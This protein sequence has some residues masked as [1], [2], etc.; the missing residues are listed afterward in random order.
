MNKI[1]SNP[2]ENVFRGP[3]SVLIMLG[4]DLIRM[5]IPRGNALVKTYSILPWLIVL[6]HFHPGGEPATR[7]CC[8]HPPY[9][10]L[11]L[12]VSTMCSHP[13]QITSCRVHVLS[14]LCPGMCSRNL[15]TSAQEL[16]IY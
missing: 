11:S 10:F 1:F 13:S 14:V 4:M 5:V 15:T 8:A 3:G 12:S 7:Q 16:G 9:T 6:F 2:T